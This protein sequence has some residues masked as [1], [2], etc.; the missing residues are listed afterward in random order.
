[1]EERFGGEEGKRE[2]KEDGKVGGGVGA[3]CIDF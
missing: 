2:K 1:L 3:R